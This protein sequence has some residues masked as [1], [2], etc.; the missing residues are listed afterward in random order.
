MLPVKVRDVLCASLLLPTGLCF[1]ANEAGIFTLRVGTPPQPPTMLVRSSDTWRYHKGTNSPAFGWQ[2][3]ADAT[4]D[5]T[6]ATGG[7]GFGFAADNPNETVRC[8]TVLSDMFNLYSTLYIRRT[9]EV[10]AAPNPTQR[11]LL[12]MDWDDGFV[13]YL[14]G[15]EVARVNAPG[16]VGV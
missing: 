11:L 7:G 5:N 3:E 15:A 9:F 13:A 10:A 12:T 1:A 4:L 16:A 14:D 8:E 6:W 2:T